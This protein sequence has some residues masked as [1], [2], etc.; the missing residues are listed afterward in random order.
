MANVIDG[1]KLRNCSLRKRRSSK[2]SL[3]FQIRYSLS[4]GT[5]KHNFKR[6]PD[7]KRDVARLGL[8]SKGRMAEDTLKLL[9]V[10]SNNK[11]FGF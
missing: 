7:L 3:H 9:E 11:T 2:S 8:P 6:L 4:K 5:E 1:V 10:S